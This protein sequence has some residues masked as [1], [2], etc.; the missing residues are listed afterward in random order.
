MNRL[1]EDTY[2]K[3][4][5]EELA[6]DERTRN[7][8]LWLWIKVLQKMGFRIYIDYEKV[9]NNEIP[10]PDT[11]S[12]ARRHIQNTEGKYP[13]TDPKVIRKREK[14][15]NRVKQFYGSVKNE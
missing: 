15:Y 2:I 10:N 7:I 4:V 6:T 11:I 5:E 12:R 8:D 9:F 3:L 14:K 13:P 1:L